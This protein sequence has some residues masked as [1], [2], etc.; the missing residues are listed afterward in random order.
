MTVTLTT[1]HCPSPVGELIVALAE[2]VLA[3]LEF[4]DHSDRLRALLQK[5]FG[6]VRFAPGA[7]SLGVA[8]RLAAYFEGDLAA[9]AGLPADGGGTPL[10]RRVWE[11]LRTIPAG[12]T[13]SYARLAAA[14]GVASAVRAVGRA[15]ALNP[16]CIVVPCHRLIG[17]DGSLRGY[18]GGLAR[19]RWLLRHEGVELG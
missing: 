15:N 14:L 2:G 8:E 18:S 17:S 13:R 19:K 4:A 1:L 3:G 16:I 6:A 12:E 7:D 11:A 5:R 10:Q 9:P